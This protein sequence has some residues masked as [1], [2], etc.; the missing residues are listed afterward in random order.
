MNLQN[1]LTLKSILIA[2]TIV[3]STHTFGGEEVIKRL[4]MERD[5]HEKHFGVGNLSIDDLT[6]IES[7]IARL[8]NLPIKELYEDPVLLATYILDHNLQCL[9]VPRTNT[10]RNNISIACTYADY[11]RLL[12]ARGFI[13]EDYLLIFSTEQFNKEKQ[14]MLNIDPTDT[15]PTFL[16]FR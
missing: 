3:F 4:T 7:R 10:Y 2:L 13:L 8:P 12:V 1:S 15:S 14:F 9:R 5:Y 16:R 6:E 11:R